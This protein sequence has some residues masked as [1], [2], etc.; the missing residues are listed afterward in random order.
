MYL[1]KFSKL[2][3]YN[4]SPKTGVRAYARTP[5]FGYFFNFRDL[6]N[7]TDSIHAKY[8][9]TVSCPCGASAV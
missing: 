5:V 6:L 4:G 8:R 3:K 7:L 9:K 1:Y 2:Q